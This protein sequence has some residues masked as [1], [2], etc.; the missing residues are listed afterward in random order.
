MFDGQAANK[1]DGR[2]IKVVYCRRSRPCSQVEE[3]IS[4]GEYKE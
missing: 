1:M 3:E 4:H 2:V